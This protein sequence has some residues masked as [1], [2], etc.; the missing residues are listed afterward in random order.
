MKAV[1]LV[2]AG[3]RAITELRDEQLPSPGKHEVLIQIHAVSLNYRD[4][5]V[6]RGEYPAKVK[7]DVIPISDGAGEVMEIG[8]GVSQVK[9]GDRIT[10]SCCTTWIGGP[11]VPEYY[12]GSVGFGTD[13]LLAEYVTVNEQA[14]VRI[15]DYMSYAEAASLPCAAVTAWTALNKIKPLQPGQTVLVQGTGG[16]SLFALQFAKVF[17][18]RVLA[19]TSSDE[20]ATQLKELG[21]D[22]VVNYRTYPDWD[23]EIL[24]LTDGKG[25]DQV[26]EIAG[27]K[28]IVKSAAST[29]LGGV[30]SIIGFASGFGGGL[31]PI[32]IL[33]RGLTVTGSMIGPRLDFEAMLAAMARHEIRPIIDQVYPFSKYQEAYQRLESGQQV[34]KVIIQVKD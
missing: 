19:I 11:F 24:A 15:P 7:E 22:A 23:R 12:T 8:P 28:T 17:G 20:K 2:K 33:S 34:G 1:R 9:P 13:G 31:P 21:A 3:T 16:V 29:K 10:V 27:E 14:L 18:A 5:A 26:I 6:L 32:D 25:V 30:I 4:I